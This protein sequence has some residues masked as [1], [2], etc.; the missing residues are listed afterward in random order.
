MKSRIEFDKSILILIIILL[1]AAAAVFLIVRNTRTDRVTE[2]IE[3][4]QNINLC[5]LIHDEESLLFTEI[6][7]YS[8]STGKGSLLDIPGETGVIIEKL[9]KIDRIDKLYTPDQPLEYIT[10]I[11]KMIEQD[12]NYYIQI[13]LKDFTA[14]VDIIGGLEM[15]I[16]NP[17]EIID[18]Q[19]TVLLPS[20]SIILDGDKAETFVTYHDP[21]ESDIDRSGRREKTVQSLLKAFKQQGEMLASD[22]LFPFFIKTVDTDIDTSSMKAFINEMANIDIGRIVFQKVLGVYR[23]V[24]NQKLLFSHY[25][26]NLLRETVRQTIESLENLDVV[27]SEELNVTLEILNGTKVNGLASR[28]SQVFQSFGY[29]V[30]HIGNAENGEIEKTIVIDRRGDIIQAQRI[31]NIIKCTN[32]KESSDEERGFDEILSGDLIES[33]DLTI[34]LGKD[35]DGRYCKE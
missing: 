24:D 30:A 31:A 19:Q 20:G 3:N 21:E 1:I 4:G 13:N 26:G 12:I 33:I 5:F 18:E 22:N 6:L 29:D 32:V 16:A 15:F 7:F 14:L 11:E 27:S 9:G 10:G 34:I 28:T 2:M 25:D 8:T 35:F 23:T 17:V